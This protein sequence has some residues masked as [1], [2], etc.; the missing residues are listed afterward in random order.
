MI[1]H[2]VIKEKIIIQELIDTF[3]SQLTLEGINIADFH[4]KM[5]LTRGIDTVDKAKLFLAPDISTMYDPFLLKDMDKAIKCIKAHIEKDNLITVYGDY[6]VDGVTSTTILY[7]MLNICGANASY[8]IPDRLEEGYGINK[9]ALQKLYDN[10]SRLVISVDTGITAVNQVEF[11]GGIGLDMIITDHH[12]CQ[13]IVP[14]AQA[15]INPKQKNC[16]YP[17]EMLA[18]VGVAYKL[19]QGLQKVFGISN[20]FVLDMLEIVAVGTISDLVPLIDENRTFVYQAFKRM[21]K[22]HN[23]GLNALIKVSGIDTKK[24][25]AGLIGFQIGPRLNAAGR[26]GDAKRGVELFLEE[27]ENLALILAEELDVENKK[28]K[29]MLGEIFL[30]AEK[31]IINNIDV[32]NTKILVIA[33]EGWHHGVIGIVASRIVEKYYRPTVLLAIE[34]G[35]ASGSARSVEGFSI[36]DALSSTKALLDKFGGHEMAAG[37][38]FDASKVKQLSA[39]LNEYANKHMDE[40]TLIQKVKIESRKTPSDI[41]TKFIDELS[42]FEPYGMSNEEPRFLV[43]GYIDS[44]TLMG[45]EQNHFKMTVSDSSKKIDT[46]GFYGSDYMDELYSGMETNVIGTFN[47]NEWKGYRKPQLFIKNI[48]YSEK[49]ELFIKYIHTMC[50]DLFENGFSDLTSEGQWLEQILSENSCNQMSLTR[51]Q[52]ITVYKNLKKILVKDRKIIHLSK[53]HELLDGKSSVRSKEL[54]EIAIKSVMCLK[55]FE[56]LKLIKI[57]VNNDSN[58]ELSINSTKKVELQKSTLYNSMC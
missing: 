40:D 15:V 54:N 34:D 53:I 22:I 55:V 3:Q 7:K 13:E 5:L 20:E 37:M 44:M 50:Y 6:D 21:E 18:G 51:N 11:A 58:L 41:T 32:K 35:V 39:N 45:K 1:K 12:E 48:T 33:H 47:V 28:R 30:E 9:A 14:N 2:I 57:R 16:Y 29:D 56:Q 23:V 46:I 31:I 17:F 49:D 52:C 26:L 36:F 8:Y 19:V 25:T 4:V 38:S 43:N 27:D 42:I 10:G 24:L